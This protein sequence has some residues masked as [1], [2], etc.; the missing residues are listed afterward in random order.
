MTSSNP[1]YLSKAPC[2]NSI[3]L[4][5]RAS[6]YDFPGET[7]ITLRKLTCTDHIKAFLASGLLWSLANG[8]HQWEMGGRR[9]MKSRVVM[10]WL[11]PL[12]QLHSACPSVLSTHLLSFQVPVTTP[13]LSIQAPWWW[14]P[15]YYWTW[16]IALS[17][18]FLCLPCILV[19]LCKKSL[20][21]PSLTFLSLSDLS[22][23]FISC[24]N[25]DILNL[26]YFNIWTY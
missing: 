17:L 6:K 8:E 5:V 10:S 18:C 25:P 21:S 4:G 22:V 14:Q 12:T 15:F 2:P 16:G 9:K 13:P 23:S 7:H 19:H 26:K 11:C 3:T 20:Y 1:N 24:Y